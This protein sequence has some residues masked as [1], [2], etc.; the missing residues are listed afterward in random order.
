MTATDQLKDVSDMEHEGNPNDQ[1]RSLRSIHIALNERDGAFE[2]ALRRLFTPG[3]GKTLT[4]NPIR[5]TAGTETR[6]ITFI[7][8]SGGGKTTTIIKVLQQFQPLQLNP[9]TDLPRYVALK[10]ES[11]A[12][13][14][15]L[16][17][18][19]LKKLGVDQ[20]SDRAKVYDIWS[21]V[22]HRIELMGISLVWI[23]EAQDMFPK[24]EDGEGRVKFSAEVENMFKMIKSLMQGNHPVVVVLSGTERLSR[25]TNLDPQINRRFHRITPPALNFADDQ[26]FIRE[27]V[28]A[29]A[30][31]AGIST[32]FS[33]TF[34]QRLIRAGRYRF[35]RCIEATI[36]AI[37]LAIDLRDATLTDEH[38]AL[39]WD[40]REGV[41]LRPNMFRATNWLEIE[42]ED[43]TGAS[44]SADQAITNAKRTRGRSGK[45]A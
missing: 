20:V 38:F 6:G 18:D 9:G 12:T 25:I 37:E 22:R 36:C 24:G 7:E 19:F 28:E 33:T 14:R 3:P 30:A 21:M 31:E 13:L 42:I 15:S 29:Y 8:G 26:T 1:P 40:A 35:G 45:A 34:F 23:D 39:D 17:V 27:I 11:P 43:E 41:S 2:R 16:G 32:R 10:V 5:F 4:H 44:E